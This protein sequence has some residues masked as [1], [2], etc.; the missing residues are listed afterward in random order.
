MRGQVRFDPTELKAQLQGDLG[1]S[2][3]LASPFAEA[4]RVGGLASS[5]HAFMNTGIACFLVGLDAPAQQ[6]L[7]KA[8]VW[9]ELAI[10]KEERPQ[11]YFPDAT[12]ALRFSDHAVLTWLL[13]SEPSPTS[14]ERCIEFRDRFWDRTGPRDPEEVSLSL[15]DYVEAGL[16]QRVLEL[17]ERSGLGAPADPLRVVSEAQMIYLLCTNELVSK[18]VDRSLQRF[19]DR[20]TGRWLGRGHFDR[21]ARWMKVAYW[22]Y[23]SSSLAPREVVLACLR[24][25]G[26]FSRSDDSSASQ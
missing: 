7:Q 5:A 24:H 9:L 6:V 26:P 21:A 23:R 14:L 1:Y 20:E 18:D 4:E 15:L 17:F 8:R 11:R 12:E 13:E 19:L 10:E 2:F 3:D 16:S 25:V 22:N